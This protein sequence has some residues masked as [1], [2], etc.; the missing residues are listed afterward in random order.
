QGLERTR[1]QAEADAALRVSQAYYRELSA[2]RLVSASDDALASARS[3]LGVA[4]ARVRA[5]VAPRLDALRGEVDLSQREI[6]GTRALEARRMARVDLE[7]AMGATLGAED[8]LEAPPGPSGEG[9]DSAAA[10]QS[11]QARRPEFA[12]LDAQILEA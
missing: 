8:T 4:R 10:L 12:A 3:H 6:A 5:G 9:L 7:S 11:A 2:A 1:E